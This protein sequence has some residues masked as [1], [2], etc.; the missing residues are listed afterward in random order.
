VAAILN[1][2][3]EQDDPVVRRLLPTQVAFPSTNG[4]L[5]I[6]VANTLYQMPRLLTMVRRLIGVEQNQELLSHVIHQAQSILDEKR[7]LRIWQMVQQKGRSVPCK[8]L[9]GRCIEYTDI[10]SYHAACFFYHSR[11]VICGTVC[12]LFEETPHLDI[13]A[14]HLHFDKIHLE[15][16]S[17]AEHIAMSVEYALRPR[18]GAPL[19]QLRIS[20]PLEVSFATWQ[21]L[22]KRDQRVFF[23]GHLQA[24]DMQDFVCDSMEKIALNWKRPL[25]S[26]EYIFALSNAY[27][28]G[29][30]LGEKSLVASQVH[31]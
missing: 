15:E 12:R 1:T 18:A 21:R 2:T 16:I 28:G 26:R 20:T 24:T 17:S 31:G 3:S 29:P 11:N 8:N 25:W 9:L 10:E 27:T 23:P 19:C 6:E 14:E 4:L 30:P 22:A 7:N 13:L 5:W